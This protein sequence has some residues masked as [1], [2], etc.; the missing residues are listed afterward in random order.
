M[1][2]GGQGVPPTPGKAGVPGPNVGGDAYPECGQ[3]YARL[4]AD[5]VQVGPDRVCRL[6]RG[7][8]GAHDDTD[9]HAKLA[10]VVH[11]PK[12]VDEHMTDARRVEILDNWRELDVNM[13]YVQNAGWGWWAAAGVDRDNQRSVAVVRED[14]TLGELVKLLQAGGQTDDFDLPPRTE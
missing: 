11:L 5:R 2:D 9:P 7:H 8:E 4:D 3:R 1:T 13:V 10:D 12:P 14:M 6:P